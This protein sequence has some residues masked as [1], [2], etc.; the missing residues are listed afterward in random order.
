MLCSIHSFIHSTHPQKQNKST[1]KKEWAKHVVIL[2]SMTL[3]LAQPYY[4]CFLMDILSFLFCGLLFT[5]IF[6]PIHSPNTITI[7]CSNR[8]LW[9][10]C[11]CVFVPSLPSLFG[12]IKATNRIISH[13]SQNYTDLIWMCCGKWERSASSKY[14]YISELDCIVALIGRNIDEFG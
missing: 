1:H 9:I 6:W 11:V 12:V 13:S 8:L 10:W 14:R 2:I 4:G 5:L 7:V 3:V